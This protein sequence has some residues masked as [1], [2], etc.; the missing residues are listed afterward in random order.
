[1]AL[2]YFAA[3]Q[4][5]LVIWETGLGDGWMP[6]ILFV[7]LVSVITNIQ[8]DHQ[9]WLGARLASIAAEKAGIIKPGIPVITGASKPRSAARHRKDCPRATRAAD[10]CDPGR[11]PCCTVGYL[12][13]RCWA[14]ISVMNAAVAVA[15]VRALRR[16]IPNAPK[17]N[18]CWSFTD[19]LARPAAIDHPN[20]RAEDSARRGAQ[21]R[22][23]GD[24]SGGLKDILPSI[25][26]TLIL[27]ILED[28]DWQ[29]MCRILAPLAKRIFLVPVSSAR[30]VEPGHLSRVWPASEQVSRAGPL[31]FGGGSARTGNV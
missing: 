20:F 3:Q 28:K 26:R 4:C 13:C 17:G 8:Y 15:T 1:M 25:K 12:D 22:W 24:L 14:I 23:R 10:A 5:D 31:R 6:P 2:R 27:G 19:K 30:A 29:G 9:E 18:P 11:N 16:Q 21:C 7:P